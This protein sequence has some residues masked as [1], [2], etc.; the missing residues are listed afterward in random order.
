MG[1]VIEKVFKFQSRFMTFLVV[2]LGWVV[3]RAENLS[4]AL[5][6]LKAMFGFEKI[7]SSSFFPNY[8]PKYLITFVLALFFS[9]PR[10]FLFFHKENFVLDDFLNNIIFLGLFFLSLLFLINTTYHPFIYFRF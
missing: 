10:S 6:I 2:I 7:L 1:I 4:S 5:S 9:W 8:A 3:F